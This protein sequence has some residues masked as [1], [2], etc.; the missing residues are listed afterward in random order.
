MISVLLVDDEP[1]VC[2]HLRTIL[3]SAPDIEVVDAVHDGVAAVEATLRLRPDVVLMDL[4]MADGDGI[5][6][7]RQL[8]ERNVSSHLVV[9][10]VMEEDEL[11]AKAIQAGAS[12]FLTKSTP[13]AD[14]IELVRVAARGHGVMSHR[15]LSRLTRRLPPADPLAT[16][17]L[18]SLT[19]R[20]SEV[21]RHLGVGLSNARIAR[22]L[23]LSEATVKGHVSRILMKLSCENRSQAA[24]LARSVWPGDQSGTSVAQS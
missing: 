8:S 1:M 14:L 6:A 11:V 12:G 9:L 21:L 15:S 2:A 17:K 10:T 5:F 24:L 23:F 20:E 3:S 16:A 4:R 7:I 13:A 18:R 19:T 22:S